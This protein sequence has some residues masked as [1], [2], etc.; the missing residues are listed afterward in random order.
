MDEIY[1]GPYGPYGYTIDANPYPLFKR[2]RDE[3]PLYRNEKY[4]FWALSRFEDVLTASKD[5]ATYSSARGTV[6]EMID[7]LPDAKPMIFHDRPEHGNLRGLMSRAFSPSRIAA[8]EPMIRDIVVD[9]LTP[10]EGRD[11]FDYL[12]DFGAKVPMMVIS[13]MLGIPE[14]DR[15][16]I[17]IWTDERLHRAEDGEELPKEKTTTSCGSCMATSPAI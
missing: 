15:E 5:H 3:A 7:K 6:L 2:M 17:R 9:L 13:S 11:S 16:Q 4:G 10:L 14:E 1:Y 12:A 8:L